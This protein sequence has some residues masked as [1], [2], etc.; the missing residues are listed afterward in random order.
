MITLIL[1]GYFIGL[2]LSDNIVP[3]SY[4]LEFQLGKKILWGLD[5]DL[6]FR[7][8]QIRSSDYFGNSTD[9]YSS[10]LD[11]ELSLPFRII[12]KKKKIH[13]F[14]LFLLFKISPYYRFEN[15]KNK[16]SQV[17]KEQ[18]TTEKLWQT[19]LNFGISTDLPLQIKDF[20]LKVRGGV[21]F[22]HLYY[23]ESKQSSVPGLQKRFQ[24]DFHTD[25]YLPLRGGL[26]IFI[27]FEF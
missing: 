20:N 25:F 21:N 4:I 14:E 12:L 24:K 22:L 27:I 17:Y 6:S 8:S 15:E 13:D 18:T 19:G 26:S 9:I 3:S 1:V 5:L 2:R 11:I 10:Y 7:E 23:R 16:S